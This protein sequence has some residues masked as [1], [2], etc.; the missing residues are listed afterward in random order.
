MDEP[1]EDSGAFGGIERGGEPPERRDDERE[2]ER[3]WSCK[4]ESTLRRGC[5]ERREE[6][7]FRSRSKGR[8]EGFED[9]SEGKEVDFVND[10]CSHRDSRFFPPTPPDELTSLTLLLDELPPPTRELVRRC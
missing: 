8:G 2:I 10:P 9:K 5:A 3:L 1:R 4:E 6:E 7:L